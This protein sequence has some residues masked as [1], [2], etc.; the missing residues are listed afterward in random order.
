MMVLKWVKMD[1]VMVNKIFFEELFQTNLFL[2]IN[3][4][5]TNPCPKTMKCENTPGSYRCIEGCEPGYQWSLKNG[6][7]RGKM[8]FIY[9]KII[10]I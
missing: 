7:C 2:D 8:G 9:S 6:E 10:S 4:C 1:V 3:E 5:L